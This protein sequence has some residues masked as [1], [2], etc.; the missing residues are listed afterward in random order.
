MALAGEI[1]RLPLRAVL[2]SATCLAWEDSVRMIYIHLDMA[3]LLTAMQGRPDRHIKIRSVSAGRPWSC[4][5]GKKAKHLD[6]TWRG[7]KPTMS[8]RVRLPVTSQRRTTLSCCLCYGVT[9]ANLPSSAT[10][11]IWLYASCLCR[12]SCPRKHNRLTEC[13]KALRTGTTNA[14][15]VSSSTLV[16]S[17]HIILNTLTSHRQSVLHI[18]LHHHPPHRLLQQEQQTQD[19]KERLHQ[20]LVV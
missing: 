3:L 7:L 4:L 8:I 6:A 11:S 19:A 12:L 16:C 10:P 13:C 15:L 14:I 2:A 9:C 18:F 5:S 17:N 1:P 20:E